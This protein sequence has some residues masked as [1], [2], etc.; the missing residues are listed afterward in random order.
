M[1]QYTTKLLKSHLRAIAESGCLRM[2]LVVVRMTLACL[3]KRVRR[4][5]SFLFFGTSVA[6]APTL[7]ATTAAFQSLSAAERDSVGYWLPRHQAQDGHWSEVGCA[8]G[9]SGL[10]PCQLDGH[11]ADDTLSTALASLSLV[12]YLR[13]F[14]NL[15]ARTEGNA[16]VRAAKR[17]QTWLLSKQRPDGIFAD[18]TEAR[19]GLSHLVATTTLLRSY[20]L[21][22]DGDSRPNE[23]RTPLRAAIDALSSVSLAWPWNLKREL[24]PDDGLV[25]AWGLTLLKELRAMRG[26]SRFSEEQFRK[27]G[28]VFDMSLY[29]RVAE[30]NYSVARFGLIGAPDWSTPRVRAL[31][32]AVSCAMMAS[33]QFSDQTELGHFS[34]SPSDERVRKFVDLY[35]PKKSEDNANVDLM[36]LYLLIKGLRWSGSMDSENSWR[37]AWWYFLNI[38]TMEGCE[39]GSVAGRYAESVGGGRVTAT[40]LYFLTSDLFVH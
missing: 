4:A 15:D 37:V 24:A 38:P 3:R 40:A 32:A 1:S 23:L 18:P 30:T 2:R 26:K 14:R 21:T 9:P 27:N 31:P 19:F 8:M 35:V 28:L 33:I 6:C 17:S 11:G 5:I 39:A 10:P 16:F 7:D 25:T 13:R 22:R 34:L 12:P 29:Q 36:V 20:E